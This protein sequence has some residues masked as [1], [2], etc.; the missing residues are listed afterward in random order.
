MN[1]LTKYIKED[2]SPT[3][4]DMFYKSIDRSVEEKIKILKDEVYKVI[5]E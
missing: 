1:N 3:L 5:N 2:I 4:E